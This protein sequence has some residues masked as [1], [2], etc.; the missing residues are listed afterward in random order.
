[1]TK[2]QKN[3]LKTIPYIA[4]AISIFF[5]IYQTKTKNKIENNYFFSDEDR[6][7]IRK[8]H[9]N[10]QDCEMNRQPLIENL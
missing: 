1:M 5:N 3:Y 7:K 6:E 9:L 10:A 2:F 8:S 4:L